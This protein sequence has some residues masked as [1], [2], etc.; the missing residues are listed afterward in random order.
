MLYCPGPLGENYGLP[1]DHM[2]QSL[3]HK[4]ANV[5]QMTNKENIPVKSLPGVSSENKV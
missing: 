4:A 3:S 1:P 2:T 5:D